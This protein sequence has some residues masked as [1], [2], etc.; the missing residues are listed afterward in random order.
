MQGRL[1]Q[2]TPGGAVVWEY[3]SPYEGYGVAGE[4]EVKQVRVP[5]VD[6]LSLTPLVYR[7]QAVPFDWT[8]LGP[9]TTALPHIDL[10]Y[11]N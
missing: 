4:P 5:G 8:P 1:F 3:H 6:R 2:V 9:P 7:S 11:R 10:R